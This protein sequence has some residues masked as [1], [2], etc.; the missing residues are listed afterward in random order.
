M[1]APVPNRA[2][3]EGAEVSQHVTCK[4]RCLPERHNTEF[5]YVEYIYVNDHQQD[6]FNCMYMYIY[7]YIIL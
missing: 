1:W 4:F 5:T 7:I 3:E 2:V 6:H